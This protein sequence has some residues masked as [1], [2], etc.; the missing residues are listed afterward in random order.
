MACN[1]ATVEV[2]KAAML[3]TRSIASLQNRS[4]R[5]ATPSI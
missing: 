5:M 4:T 3:P 1:A 2:L